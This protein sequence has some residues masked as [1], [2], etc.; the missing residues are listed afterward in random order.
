MKLEVACKNIPENYGIIQK[1]SNAIHCSMEIASLLFYRGIDTEAKA[2]RFIAP[3]KKWYNDPYLL[4]G[5]K[6]A[7]NKIYE[8]KK[9]S[10]KVL[11][12]GDYDADGI[13]ASSLLTFC[14]REFGISPLTVVPEREENYGINIERMK[15]IKSEYDFS[16]LITV[17]CGISEHD[18]I[19]TIKAM[20]VDVIVTDHHEPPEILPDCTVINPKI[21][22]QDY[23]FDGLCGAGVAFKLGTAL[24]GDEADKYVDMVSLA[25]I[26]DSMDLISENRDIVFEGLKIFN[27]SKIR[28]C[29]KYLLGENNKTITASSLAFTIAPR[30]NAGGRMGDAKTALDLLLSEDENVMFDLAVKLNA[31]N[32]QRQAECDEIYKQAKAKLLQENLSQTEIILVGDDSWNTGFIGIV[33]SRL[34]EEYNKPSIVFGGTNGLLKGSARSTDGINIHNAILY[35]ADLTVTFGGHSQAAGVT[36]EKKNFDEFKNKIN[37][38]V[39]NTY[40]AIKKE[41]TVKVDM[42]I[43]GGFSYDFAKEI[44]NLE[45]F[46]IANKRPLFASRIG[47]VKSLPIRP[48]S[49]HFSFKSMGLEFLDFNG[50]NDVLTLL[51][52]TDKYIVYETSLSSFKG[53]EYLKGYL[54]NIIIDKLNTYDSDLFFFENEIKKL[55]YDGKSDEE[56]LPF[57]SFSFLNNNG[58]TV[59][60]VSDVNNLKHYDKLGDLPITTYRVNARTR[61]NVIIVSPT[62][63][64]DCYDRIVYLDEPLSFVKTDKESYCNFELS[65]FD[66]LDYVETD[67]ACMAEV[68]KT[69]SQYVGK[70]FLS[71]AEAFYRY[72]PDTEMYQFVFGAEVFFE[73]GFFE[74]KNGILYINKETKKSLDNSLIYNKVFDIRG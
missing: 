62:E 57:D 33:A 12:F 6:Q 47:A 14:L 46:G 55:K 61:D 42:V 36:V 22:G 31:Y 63:M 34:T 26:A 3:G 70:E 71:S 23:P 5:M 13:C 64:P 52:P 73:L 51:T 41:K 65:G 43:D 38:Y 19:E 8:A 40:G 39:R 25:T 27:S 18:N 2:M 45:P 21:K 11:V 7:I 58:G 74:I 20:G 56:I 50:E 4:K 16:L 67:R 59:F 69:I 53:K 72:K 49:P 10:K 30:I 15:A 48:N 24:I 66:F 32:V 44:E 54:K 1:I 28:P 29:F 35:C 9:E 17:D 37:E 68:Y 60:A